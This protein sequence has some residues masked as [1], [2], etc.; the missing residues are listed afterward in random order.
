MSENYKDILTNLST[1]V[2]QET[3]LL[4]LKGRLDDV[5]KREIE[6]HLIDNEFSDD[7]LEGLKLLDEQKITLMVDQ[8]NYDLKRKL[9]KKNRFRDKLKFK[10]QPWLYISLLI[11]L[12]LIVIIYFAIHR[13]LNQ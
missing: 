9:K 11:F 8:I 7:A 4:Y 5:R 3:L 2:D 6:K 10:D 13:I 12:L 1:D